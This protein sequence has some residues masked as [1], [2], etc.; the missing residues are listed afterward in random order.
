MAIAYLK[1]KSEFLADGAHIAD[2]VWEGVRDHLGIKLA[3]D[4]SEYRSWASSLNAMYWVLNDHS[5]PENTG[6]A[7]EFRIV[8]TKQRIDMLLSG[9][10]ATSSQS[11]VIELKQWS[12]ASVDFL[13]LPD[14]VLMMG[15]REEHPS[16]QAADY[17]S[18]LTDFYEVVDSEPIQLSSCAY[19]H[20]LEDREILEATVRPETL[21]GSPFF[22]KNEEVALRNFI[23][24]RISSGD[25]ASALKL[26]DTSPISPS[27][28]LADR[29]AS[30]LRGNP[31]FTLKG[32]QRTAFELIRK[33]VRDTG[34]TD[35]KVLIVK[36]GPGTGKSVIALRMLSTAINESLNARYVTKNAAPRSVYAQKLKGDRQGPGVRNL[37]IGADG[38]HAHVGDRFDLLLVDE[39]HR[40]VHKSGRFKNLGENQIKE[41]IEASKVSVFFIDENQAVTWRDMGTIDEIASRALSLGIETEVVDLEVQFRCAGAD[42][43]MAW[44]DQT[45]GISDLDY[46]L[47]LRTD[48]EVEVFDSPSALRDAI[49]Q[50]NRQGKHDSRLLAGYCWDWASRDDPT[51]TDINFEEENFAMQWNLSRHGQGWMAQPD[52][53]NQVGCVFTSQGLEGTYMGV[54]MGDD[55]IVRDGKVLSNVK[56]RAKT[57]RDSLWGWKSAMKKNPEAT[58]AKIDHIIKNQYRVLMTRGMKGTYLYST[59]LETREYLRERVAAAR[60]IGHAQDHD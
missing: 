30:M 28:Q 17:A 38:F 40:L 16:A 21:S 9:R 13:D 59:D 48:Y 34:A 7:L 1:T 55:L 2:R 8:G 18:I 41:I 35:R 52:G 50:K 42:D 26:I 54:I 5:V 19:L 11:V 20:N 60:G 44:L 47:P 25:G 53:V 6:V 4:G 33:A 57:D 56:A 37:L 29:M 39:A 45:L 58:Q 15:R 32:T 27:R 22:I 43:Y 36:G 23:S 51:Q 31:E 46:T 3:K 24:D 14:H 12:D 49:F 10:D